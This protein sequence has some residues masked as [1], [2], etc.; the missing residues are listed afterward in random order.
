MPR[1]RRRGKQRIMDLTTD[2]LFELMWGP[3]SPSEFQSPLTRRAAYFYHRDEVI[4]HHLAGQRP[5][6]FYEFDLGEHPP[7]I[8]N[9][10][11][12]LRQKGLL[13]P[14]EEAQLAIWESQ[15]RGQA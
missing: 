8:S 14:W 6:A 5:W 12:F 2:Q 1:A 15:V 11:A 9:Q 3:N 7:E 4:E 13:E 10:A